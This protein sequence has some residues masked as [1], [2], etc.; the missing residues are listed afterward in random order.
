MANP[1]AVW[2]HRDQGTAARRSA[3]SERRGQ[4][5][6]GKPERPLH[7]DYRR[8]DQRI[9]PDIPAAGFERY[10]G[11]EQRKEISGAGGKRF[12]RRAASSGSG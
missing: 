5:G 8:Q 4:G 12:A 1:G 11:G 3:Q 6:D 9:L 7:R 10:R 2:Q